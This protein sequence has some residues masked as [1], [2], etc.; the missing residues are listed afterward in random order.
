MA[1]FHLPKRITVKR[2]TQPIAN[3]SDRIELRKAL[4]LCNLCATYRM[5]GNWGRRFGYSL[6][7]GTTAHGLCDYCR[8]RKP[9]SVYTREEGRLAQDAQRRERA[10]AMYHK[11]DPKN[12]KVVVL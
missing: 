3:V 9:C 11:Q 8:E 7:S 5:P 2:T 10:M 1:H 6:M 12:P 4:M